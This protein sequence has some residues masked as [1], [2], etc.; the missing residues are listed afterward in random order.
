MMNLLVVSL[1]GA[2]YAG[3]FVWAFRALPREEWQILAAIPRS[4]QSNG[5]WMGLNLTYYGLFTATGATMA[6]ATVFVLMAALK[7]P[8]LITMWLVLVLLIC[9]TPSAKIVA[10]F[11]EKKANTL[12]VGGSAFVGVVL[13]PWIILGIN[14]TGLAGPTTDK[15]PFVSTMAILAIA[16]ALGEGT[17]RL[18][19]ISF[20]CCYGK[21][22]SQLPS[23]ISRLFDTHHFAFA[24]ATKKA[25]YEGRLE[26]TPLVPVQGI[27][28]V[29]YV[30]VGLIGLALFLEGRAL[31]AFLVAW[32]VTQVWRAVSEMLRAD[33]RG[34][35]RISTYQ[36]LA[37]IG[38]VYGLG[39]AL[40]FSERES[41]IPDLVAGL[42]ALWHPG[43]ILSLQSTWVAMFLYTGRSKV[44][45]SHLALSVV[46][47]QI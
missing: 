8:L 42:H 45:A 13:A 40:L 2:L 41:S 27:T 23:W 24:G 34:G 47:D 28:A 6:A 18:A 7:V 35:R 4:R 38:A 43:V 16:Y 36:V 39:I 5:W 46:R 10:R 20:G 14:F 37:L 19:C 1:L 22:L 44:T 11:V 29:L 33:F 31:A 9:A 17:G 25:A 12:T 30:A 3:L 32:L 26:G 15:M 21:P